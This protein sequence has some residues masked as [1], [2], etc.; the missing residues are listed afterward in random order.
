MGDRYCVGVYRST[1]RA[2][3]A[4]MRE[5]AP[6]YS[7][8]GASFQVAASQFDTEAAALNASAE[9]LFPGWQI[10]ETLDTETRCRAASLVSDARDGYARAIDEIEAG[11]GMFQA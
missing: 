8:A 3:G 6:R 11:L 4:F 7:E 9:L 10:P 2:A 5:I 1:R